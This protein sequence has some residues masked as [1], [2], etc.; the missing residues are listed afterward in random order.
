MDDALKREDLEILLF[1][2]TSPAP[3]SS[4]PK[5]HASNPFRSTSP[6]PNSRPNHNFI[7]RSNNKTQEEMEDLLDGIP[8]PNDESLTSF[9]TSSNSNNTPQ[10]FSA[11]QESTSHPPTA[12]P[13]SE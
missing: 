6:T 10:K 9:T 12:F 4:K 2:T 7:T 3:V 13:T 8:F 11:Q 5:K 1:N